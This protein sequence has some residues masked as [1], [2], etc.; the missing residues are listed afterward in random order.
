M[1][2]RRVEVQSIENQLPDMRPRVGVTGI[3]SS[4]ARVVKTHT[5]RDRVTCVVSRGR[6]AVRNLGSMSVSA[7]TAKPIP[8]GHCR[9][10]THAEGVE[11]IITAIADE[12]ILRE[13]P[14]STCDTKSV[15]WILRWLL[16][17]LGPGRK[18]EVGDLNSILHIVG[19]DD[20]ACW[21]NCASLAHNLSVKRSD[22]A[23]KEST[24]RRRS[25]RD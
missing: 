3:G 13:V 6:G 10:Q 11:T 12:K 24:H 22:T 18:V 23:F 17:E 14:R 5:S 19:R 15:I 2:G 4:A 9:V 21:V 8:L 1:S 16:T 7:I 25:R 20:G